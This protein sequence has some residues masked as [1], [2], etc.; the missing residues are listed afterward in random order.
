MNSCGDDDQ[1]SSNSSSTVFPTSSD[2]YAGAL[3]EAWERGDRDTAARFA[4]PNALET[5]F[6]R[7]GGGAGSSLLV[8]CDG[9]MGSTY[10]TFNNADG[11][12]VTLRVSNEAVI[13]GPNA[14]VEVTFGTAVDE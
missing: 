14:V 2:N 1:A 4:E 10:C 8:D 11:S 5:L 9:A 3:I 13:A 6:S 7:E 12:A